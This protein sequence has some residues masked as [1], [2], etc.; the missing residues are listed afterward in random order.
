[1]AGFSNAADSADRKMEPAHNSFMH[2]LAQFIIH[3]SRCLAV[4]SSHVPFDRLQLSLGNLSEEE[5][6]QTGAHQII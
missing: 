3:A 4:L 6:A 1:M 2:L 5:W